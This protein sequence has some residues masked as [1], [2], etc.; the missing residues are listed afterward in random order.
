MKVLKII[1]KKPFQEKY[2][3]FL[4][5]YGKEKDSLLAQEEHLFGK[6]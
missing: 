2:D 6:Y 1:L 3:L 5:P 4:I